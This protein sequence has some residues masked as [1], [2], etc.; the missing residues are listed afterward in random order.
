M[1]GYDAV[2]AAALLTSSSDPPGCHARPW[3]DRLFFSLVALA[4][5]AELLD[6]REIAGIF[7]RDTDFPCDLQM[8][9][10]RYEALRHAPRIEECGRFPS[11][12]TAKECLALNRA[13]RQDL[14]TRLAFDRT[15]AEE[16]GLALEDVDHHYRVWDALRDAASPCYFITV[17][18]QGLN[19]L[20][21]L[22]GPEAFYRG[23]TPPPV[24]LWLLH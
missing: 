13:V 21:A 3:A 22:L 8:L 18:R 11:A 1:F 9:N 7:Q 23:H 4:L 16:L 10:E 24:P 5:D 2:L 17:R 19:R 15:H 6:P 20:R 14:Q 12:A